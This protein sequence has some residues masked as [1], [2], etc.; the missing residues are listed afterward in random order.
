MKK[1]FGAAEI[2]V[3]KV[4]ALHI[5]KPEF[6]SKN[7]CKKPGVVALVHHPGAGEVEIGRSLEFADK[8]AQL[9]SSRPMR[10][11]VS[12]TKQKNKARAEEGHSRLSFGLHTHVHRWHMHLH[13]YK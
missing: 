2:V 5:Q 6:D 8:T 10:D 3:G 7:P 13:T 9:T 1:C 12:K 4:L 11:L